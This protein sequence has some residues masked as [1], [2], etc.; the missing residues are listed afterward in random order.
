MRKLRHISDKI[1]NICVCKKLKIAPV[2]DKM[3]ENRLRWF[4][5][6]GTCNEGQNVCWL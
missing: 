5:P 3:G 4:R 2:E 1:K 6:L